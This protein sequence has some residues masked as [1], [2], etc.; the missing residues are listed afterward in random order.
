GENAADIDLVQS[1]AFSPDGEML[2]TGGFRSV[3]LWAKH[4]P[5]LSIDN[6]QWAD[7][8]GPAVRSGDGAYTAVVSAIGDIEVWN[9]ESNERVSVLS[10]H[11]DPIGALAFSASGEQIISGDHGGRMML[12]NRATGEKVSEA[13]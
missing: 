10:G 11:A 5:S 1:L 13:T 6:T 7:A 12:W 3:K 9:R 4:Y 2:A 8:S